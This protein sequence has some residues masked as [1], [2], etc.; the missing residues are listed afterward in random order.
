[1]NELLKKLR[2]KVTLRLDAGAFRSKLVEALLD[3]DEVLQVK[4]AANP[5]MMW[6][7]YSPDSNYQVGNCTF[8]KQYYFVGVESSVVS[9]LNLSLHGR[10]THVYFHTQICVTNH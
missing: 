9:T 1:M 8:L 2:S 6:L 10:I 7:W 3:T 5:R 4:I